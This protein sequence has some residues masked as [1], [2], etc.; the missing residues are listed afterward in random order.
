M[1]RRRSSVFA[2]LQDKDTQESSPEEDAPKAFLSSTQEKVLL[3]FACLLA[4]LPPLFHIHLVQDEWVDGF[5]PI[6]LV[7]AELKFVVVLVLASVLVGITFI[8]LH[9]GK[10]FLALPRPLLLCLGLFSLVFARSR[11]FARCVAASLCSL[12]PEHL[13]TS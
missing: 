12:H 10:R 11:V 5:I 4:I 3:V 1:S 7:N 13:K 8:S 9:L 2:A 6:R